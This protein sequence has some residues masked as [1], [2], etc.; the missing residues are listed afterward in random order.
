[1]ER[2]RSYCEATIVT[3]MVRKKTLLTKKRFFA[4]YKKLWR[5]RAANNKTGSCIIVWAQRQ[6]LGKAEIHVEDGQFCV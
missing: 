6:T 2:M 1:M 3:V 5:G 4:T